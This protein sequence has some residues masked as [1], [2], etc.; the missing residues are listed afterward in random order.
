MC[1]TFCFLEPSESKNARKDKEKEQEKHA[2]GEV[3]ERLPWLL[4]KFLIKVTTC[5]QKII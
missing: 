3:C 4:R 1:L 5:F 2:V